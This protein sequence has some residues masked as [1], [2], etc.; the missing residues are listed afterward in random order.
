LIKARYSGIAA[1]L[2][3]ATPIESSVPACTLEVVLWK[4]YD[5]GRSTT[6]GPFAGAIESNRA[7]LKTVALQ[8]EPSS[9]SRTRI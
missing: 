3:I 4:F 8:F 6:S 1:I 7:R 5:L 9:G 2:A